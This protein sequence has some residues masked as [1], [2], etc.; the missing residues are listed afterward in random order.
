MRKI[1]IA[2]LLLSL[3]SINAQQLTQEQVDSETYASFINKEYKTTIKIGKQ[4][5]KAGVDFYY[6]RYRMGVSYYEKLRS[7][8]SSS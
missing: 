3:C 4:S 8:H 1:L 6:L 7:S 2:L 5:I